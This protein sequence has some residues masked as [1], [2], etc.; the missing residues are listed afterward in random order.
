M[1][2]TA[3]NVEKVFG[4]C[5]S[6]RKDGVVKC[7]VVVHSFSFC[8]DK[9]QENKQNIIDMLRQYGNLL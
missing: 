3:E 7:D 4:D 8:K 5:F 9:L 6:E 1:N 2:L